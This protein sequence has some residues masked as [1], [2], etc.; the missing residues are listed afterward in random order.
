MKQYCIFIFIC[1]FNSIL[2]YFFL[3]ARYKKISNIHK[4]A[5][6]DETLDAEFHRRIDKFQLRVCK[7]IDLWVKLK[8]LKKLMIEEETL[9]STL[10]S[11]KSEASK[12]TILATTPSSTPTTSSL[13][14]PTTPMLVT[15]GTPPPPVVSTTPVLSVIPATTPPL[16]PPPPHPPRRSIFNPR[17]LKQ[18]IIL[19]LMT[20]I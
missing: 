17:K 5:A 6:T 8:D 18:S 20:R 7:L 1:V 10:A 4:A 12:P 2:F 19:I 11:I 3:P 13:V 16:P 9:S 15:L 14:T